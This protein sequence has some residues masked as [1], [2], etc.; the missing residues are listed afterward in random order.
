MTAALPDTSSKLTRLVVGPLLKAVRCIKLISDDRLANSFVPVIRLSMR[1]L[2]SSF[3]W[4]G[5]EEFAATLDADLESLGQELEPLDGDFG[6]CFSALLE[7]VCPE[8]VLA[9]SVTLGLIKRARDVPGLAQSP[10]KS[11]VVNQLLRD[12]VRDRLWRLA[13]LR[14][15][16]QEDLR[17]ADVNDELI[18]ARCYDLLRVVAFLEDCLQL[19]TQFWLSLPEHA[20]P[21]EERIRGEP[22][23]AR[24]NRRHPREVPGPG[25][26]AP[27]PG[28]L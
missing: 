1:M 21:L 16:Q 4:F 11:A 2:H 7:T 23:L 22:A 20:V 13:T 15:L 26:H 5:S 19:Q 8:Y 17:L 10:Q 14:L 24:R 12:T 3:G 18:T 27:E 25:Q 6:E 28:L 9:K